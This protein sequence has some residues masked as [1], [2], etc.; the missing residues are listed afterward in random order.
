MRSMCRF[1][2]SK[3]AQMLID[4]T[5]RCAE[6][7]PRTDPESQPKPVIVLHRRCIDTSKANDDTDAASEY[8]GT[9]ESE[10]MLWAPMQDIQLPHV[11]HISGLW[12]G[13]E[14]E[15]GNLRRQLTELAR[16]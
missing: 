16:D 12:I 1:L 11:A 8:R 10:P 15:E 7:C 13:R 5:R 9:Q 3:T 6:Q 4:K 14:E 2:R